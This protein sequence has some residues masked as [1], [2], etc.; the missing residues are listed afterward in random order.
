M[1]EVYLKWG[2][3]LLWSTCLYEGHV[4]LLLTATLQFKKSR[5]EQKKACFTTGMSFSWNHYSSCTSSELVFAKDQKEFGE[6]SFEADVGDVVRFGA[7]QMP[8]LAQTEAHPI[9][10]SE[11]C[12]PGLSYNV[13]KRM[14][15]Y[16][17]SIFW[18]FF[19]YSKWGL[20]L[21]DSWTLTRRKFCPLNF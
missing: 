8:I 15:H 10:P 11:R 17:D 9:K 13:Q 14:V 3:I 6:C 2:F 20:W 5:M 18:K 21:V 19:P 1:S 7:S 4:N 16:Q 12:Q